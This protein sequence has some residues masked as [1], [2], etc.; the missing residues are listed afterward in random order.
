[1]YI[2]EGIYENNTDWILN[3][4]SFS[5]TYLHGHNAF[6]EM[7]K[8]YQLLLRYRYPSNLLQVHPPFFH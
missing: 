8:T 7:L 5:S 2:Y 6:R 4:H 1:M 3:N